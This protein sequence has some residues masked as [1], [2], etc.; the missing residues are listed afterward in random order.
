MDEPRRA[1]QG[2]VDVA[3]VQM[4]YSEVGQPSLALGLLQADCERNRVKSRVVHANMWFSEEI[5]PAAFDMIFQAY[6]TTLIGEWTFGSALFPDFQP[7]DERYLHK[8]VAMFK[9]DSRSQWRHLQRRYP[10]LDQ[11]A[12]LREIRKR[13]PDFVERMADRI[14]ELEPKI[15]GCSSTFQQHCA[16][17]A[18]LR[19]VK[20]RRPDVVTMIGG[21]NCE[22]D[23]GRATFEQ[24]PWL[25]FVA[26]GEADG[27]FGALCAKVLER[28]A[29]GVPRELVPAGLWAP[30]HRSDQGAVEAACANQ[31]DG[32][33]IARLDDMDDSPIPNYDDYFA[34]LAETDALGEW[35]RPALPF[36]TARGCWWG[37]KTHCSFCGI[38]RTA[39]KFRSKSGDNVI[40]QMLAMKARYGISNFQGT[41]YIFDYRYFDTLLPRLKDIGGYFR[42]E[43]KANLKPEQFQS[44][45]D[46]GTL[47]VQPG[48][49]S[50]HDEL[51]G[52]LK[53]G[54]T[55]RQNILLLK[56]AQQ[57]G[58]LVY[59][60]LLYAIPGDKDEWYAE[61]A[62]LI[63]LVSHLQAPAGLA[64]IHYDRF[65]PYWRDPARHGL[66]LQ[67]AFGY[68]F[69]YPLP[70][71]RLRDLAYFFETPHQRDAFYRIHRIENAG[72][73]RVLQEVTAWKNAWTG[74]R[75][76]PSLV[77]EDKGDR[78]VFKDTRAVATAAAFEITGLERR[79][80]LLAE[81]GIRPAHLSKALVAQG[82]GEA[83]IE[84]AIDGLVARKVM[85]LVSGGLLSL[86]VAAPVPPFLAHTLSVPKSEGN[87]PWARLQADK[88]L[89][90]KR[91]NIALQCLRNPH[92]DDLST[93]LQPVGAASKKQE[94]FA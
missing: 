52:L 36:Q 5:G 30:H 69:V 42:F 3:L 23:M 28:G 86:G 40:E 44:F 21:A 12:L 92:D 81:D 51:L 71:E 82:F 22:G 73:L 89:D 46:S 60:N 10:Y 62:D 54:V 41:E 67:P 33:P 29:E 47:E 13:A 72:L 8:V 90:E 83:E 68:E 66:T 11:V 15:V 53:K 55:A 63:P 88:A 20:Q 91:P 31:V 39:M 26:S 49:E 58:L 75:N 4:P 24:F 48:V 43:V 17:L 45:V 32:A 84:A 6:S 61:M 70:P 50:L 59:W 79:A 37:E 76:A 57:V 9:L 77:A 65:S 19:A 35:V 34:Y 80:Y 1:H 14:L 27:F 85:A 16:S 93:W 64:Q 56:R 2:P 94:S 18:L 74:A 78:I 87:P 38:S 25:D 7:D